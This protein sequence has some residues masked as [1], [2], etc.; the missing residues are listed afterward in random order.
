MLSHTPFGSLDVTAPT[1]LEFNAP[2]GLE[3]PYKR[4]TVVSMLA[5]SQLIDN[6]L[7]QL[8]ESSEDFSAV[9]RKQKNS[10]L[11]GMNVLSEATGLMESRQDMPPLLS[12]EV[13]EA[14]LEFRLVHGLARV[15]LDMV[16]MAE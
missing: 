12:P 1:Y 3:V 8:V 9:L 15:S 14:H 2:R 5:L 6:R 10:V 4:V 13:R 16:M 7:G 11:P